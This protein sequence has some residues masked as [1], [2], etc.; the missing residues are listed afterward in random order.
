[1]NSIE[2]ARP[3]G[4]RRMALAAG[5]LGIGAVAAIS[6]STAIA[7]TQPAPGAQPAAVPTAETITV[8]VKRHALSGQRL[9]L[10]GKVGSGTKGRSVL[11]Q[12]RAGKGWKTVAR[13]LTRAGGRFSAYWRL[14]G[15]G[16]QRVRAFVRGGDLP[17]AAREVKG[18]V[19]GYRTANASWYGPGFYGGHLACGGTLNAGTVGVAHKTL[20]CGSKVTLRYKGRSLTVKVIDRGPY[21]GGRDFDLTAATKQKLRFGST[22]QVWSTK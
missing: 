4:K 1:V 18:G 20:P 7:Q 19:T 10:G 9:K 21:V 14:E 16:K 3:R 2:T 17:V 15:M 5:V 12:K 13:T 22:G 11:I 8:S 6:P